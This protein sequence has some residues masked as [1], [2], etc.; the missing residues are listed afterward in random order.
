[1]YHL[2]NFK[3]KFSWD[4][5][6][7][8]VLGRINNF[9]RMWGLFLSVKISRRNLVAVLPQQSQEDH[10]RNTSKS[11]ITLGDWSLFFI[12]CS[13]DLLTTG[14]QTKQQCSISNVVLQKWPQDFVLLLFHH[15]PV[16]HQSTHSLTHDHTTAHHSFY[17]KHRDHL[18]WVA[19][20]PL[21]A[22]LK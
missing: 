8:I 16:F 13:P 12:F 1:M 18:N 6:G 7:F 11:T 10:C 21:A 14:C 9:S 22:I 4:L 2:Y 19:G 5:T 17:F 3:I 20:T 15:W